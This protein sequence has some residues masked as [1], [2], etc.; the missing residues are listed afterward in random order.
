MNLNANE[1]RKLRKINNVLQLFR[2]R[3]SAANETGMSSKFS[4]AMA[5]IIDILDEDAKTGDS[6]DN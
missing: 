3:Y 2:D 4:R 5:I 6:Y 1:R